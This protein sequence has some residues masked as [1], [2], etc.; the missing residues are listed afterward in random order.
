MSWIACFIHKRIN[1]QIH[2]VS[3]FIQ[4]VDHYLRTFNVRHINEHFNDYFF[5]IFNSFSKENIHAV[6]AVFPLN[7]KHLRHQFVMNKG[8]KTGAPTHHIHFNRK[9][10]LPERFTC[11]RKFNKGKINFS[12]IKMRKNN[13]IICRRRRIDGHKREKMRRDLS[14]IF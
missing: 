10:A 3:P 8:I 9:T 4:K 7:I 6:S 12:H 11:T 5:A 14:A 1:R 13:H 2:V